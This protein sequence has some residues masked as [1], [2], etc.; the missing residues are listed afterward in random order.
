MYRKIIFTILCCLVFVSHGFAATHYVTEAGGGTTCTDDGG[1]CSKAELEALTGTGY[2]DDTFYFSGSISSVTLDSGFSGT[3]GHQVIFDGY[4]AGSCDPWN[5]SCAAGADIGPVVITGNDYIT[6]QD[7]DFQSAGYNFITAT[8]SLSEGLIIRRNHFSN[9]VYGSIVLSYANICT[10]FDNKIEKTGLYST[11]EI[12]SGHGHKIV[13]NHIRGI[14]NGGIDDSTWTGIY[15]KGAFSRGGIAGQIKNNIVA[16]N[17]VGGILEECISFDVGASSA[18]STCLEYDTVSSSSTY[19]VTLNDGGWSGAANDLY[20]GAYMFFLSG[21]LAGEVYKITD[22]AQAVFTFVEDV[23]SAGSTDKIV[24]ALP[25]M[26]NYVGY[27][28]VSDYGWGY[29]SVIFYGANYGNLV[30]GHTDNQDMWDDSEAI[31]IQ[32]NTNTYKHTGAITDHCGICPAWNILAYNNTIQNIDIIKY[33]V[34]GQ[35]EDSPPAFQGWYNS[36]V[37]NDLEF[38]VK[39]VYQNAY[40]SGSDIDANS[41]DYTNNVSYKYLNPYIIGTPYISLAGS[42]YID[43]SETVDFTGY[44]NGDLYLTTA[45]DIETT[46]ALN[47]SSGSGAAWVFTPASTPVQG[48]TYKLWHNGTADSIVNAA[49]NDM[50]V[51]GY[52]PISNYYEDPITDPPSTHRVLVIGN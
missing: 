41:A 32:T 40:V 12:D 47:S 27:N 10:I 17:D 4:E 31:L 18:Y 2:A 3:S 25:F 22:H 44:T 36:T 11:V 46:I 6:F 15:F 8:D 14:N 24:I 16:G 34:P 35:C 13:K 52:K 39:L 9:S 19:T 33:A 23:S 38:D 50:I 48:E 43:W 20:N 45:A 7:F 1:T 42:V 49:D 26:D 29:A 30:E 37:G 51:V 21:T 28:T 5:D